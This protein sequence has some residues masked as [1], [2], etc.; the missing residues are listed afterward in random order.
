MPF[1]L[2]TVMLPS[3]E[4]EDVETSCVIEHTEQ[5]PQA[6]SGRAKPSGAH[7]ILAYD[8]LKVMSAGGSVN[9]EDLMLGIVAKTPK[10]EGR[11][12]RRRN[13]ERAL[14]SLIAKKLAFMQGEDRVSLTTAIEDHAW[15]G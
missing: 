1:K 11:D 5:E 12:F 15:L 8:T 4:G 9:L 7:Q 6:S 3:L 2:K 10:T 14:H 13:A